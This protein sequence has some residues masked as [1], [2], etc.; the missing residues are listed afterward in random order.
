MRN[1]EGML[2]GT[3]AFNSDVSRWDVSRVTEMGYLFAFST[4]FNQP[5]ASWNV[6]RVSSMRYL[7]SGAAAFN[8]RKSEFVF[9]FF[10]VYSPFP[11]YA[12]RTM[13]L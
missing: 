13:Q 8:Q 12:Y 10:A 6:Q 9:F 2:Q 1:M 5:L 4:T 7:F 11:H 3:R